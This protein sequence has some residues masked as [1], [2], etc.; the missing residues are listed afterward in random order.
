MAQALG[1]TMIHNIKKITIIGILTMQSLTGAYADEGIRLNDGLPE[2]VD[3][4]TEL[5]EIY[6]KGMTVTYTYQLKNIDIQEAKEIK[7]VNKDFIEHNACKDEQIRCLLQKDLDV[8]FV[9]KIKNEE[10]LQVKLN[11]DLCLRL[12][13][14]NQSSCAL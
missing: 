5:N 3:S 13:E 8:Q 1:G 11:R 9:Y 2:M 4:K 7:E 6:I 10:I 12:N 14:G